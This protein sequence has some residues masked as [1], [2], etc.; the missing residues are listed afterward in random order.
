MRS[1]ADRICTQRVQPEEVERVK[2]KRRTS[3]AIESEVPYHRLTELMDDVEYRGAPRTVKQML[4][5]VEAVTVDTIQEYFQEF[6]I[7]VNGHLTSVGPQCTP[8]AA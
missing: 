1:E 3:L 4:S 5:E 7:N 6:P 2:N 8:D